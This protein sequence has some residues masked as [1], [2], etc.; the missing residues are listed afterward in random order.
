MK[1]FLFVSF[2]TMFLITSFLMIDQKEEKVG[3][4][5]SNNVEKRGI[6]ISYIELNNYLK[7]K[8]EFTSKNNIIKILDNI[9]N[10]KY[11]MVIV[12]V[13]AFSDSIYKSKIFP[14]S[15]SVKVNGNIPNYDI[16]SFFIE[17]AHKR[18]LDFYAWINPYRISTDS[19]LSN[20]E[21]T[22]PAYNLIKDG[23]V[24]VVKDKGIYYNPAHKGVEKL[25]IDGVS[26]I[27][28]NYSV[29][30]ILFDDYFYPSNEIDIDSYNDYINSGGEQDIKKYRYNIVLSL[31]KN[32]YKT[33]KNINDK[34]NFTISP[35]GNISN[36]YNKHYL[37]IKTILSNNGYIDYI[38]PQVYFGFDNSNKPFIDTVTEWNDLIKVNSIKLIPALAFY[39]VGGYDKYAGSGK[40][41]WIE[42]SNIISRQIIESRKL[43]NYVGFSIFRYDYMFNKTKYNENTNDEL[44]SLKN[45]LN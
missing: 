25:I 44:N 30:G 33:I 41:E 18:K 38:M 8:D 32:V 1:N 15:E 45:V 7:N 40:N 35:E 16:L 4:S 10:N 14:Y 11:N 37:D 6:F 29:D 42:N 13:R 23:G 9:K 3:S 22:H 26:E 24:K 27:V 12:H 21:K 5:N 34:V 20:I 43:K 19:D 31:I 36:N 39:K 28:K 17:E 2:F